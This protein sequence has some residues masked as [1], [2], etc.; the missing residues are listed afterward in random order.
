MAT[1]EVWL[2][3]VRRSPTYS[4]HAWHQI[5]AQIVAKGDEIRAKKK[6]GVPKA[7]APKHTPYHP[8][9]SAAL[10]RL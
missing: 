4:P 1:T 9:L 7:V 5:Q 10:N 6:E 8:A 3:T 2:S